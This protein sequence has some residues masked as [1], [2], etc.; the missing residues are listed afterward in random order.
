MNS[1]SGP[2]SD[3]PALRGEVVYYYAFDF[4]YDMRRVPLES[5]LGC[6][7]EPFQVDARKRMPRGQ[8][9]YQPLVARLPDL[10]QQVHEQ[11]VTLRV[12]VK[13]LFIGALSVTVRV[14]LAVQTPAEC[15][16][17]NEL[18]FDDGSTL[19]QW[20]IA[21]V[22]K[23]RTEL[24]AHAIRPLE[25]LPEPESYTVFCL[26]TDCPRNRRKDGVVAGGEPGGG[27]GHVDQ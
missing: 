19:E 20:V 11:P 9:F 16:R 3:A 25:R 14:P 12:A 2:A 26:D 5:L 17:W 21:T 7:L 24:K 10:K 27:G 6:P 4:A 1:Q 15:S 18:I 13:V 22:E 8:V 23:A